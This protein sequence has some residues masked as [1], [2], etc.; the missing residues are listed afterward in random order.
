MR[1]L[2]IA[3]AII[4]AGVVVLLPARAQTARAAADGERSIRGVMHV[5]TR[6]SDGTGTIEQVADAA[7]RAGLAFVVVTDHGDA[8]RPPDAPAYHRGVLMIDAVEVSTAGGHVVALGLDGAPYPLG[9]APADVV[10]DIHRLGGIAIAA[11]PGSPRAELAW[12][13]W[14]APVDGLEWVNGDSEWRDETP[15][16]LLRGLLTYPFR[17]PEALAS[18]LDRPEPVMRQWDALAQQRPVVGLAASDAHARISLTSIGEP[19]DTHASLPFPS[20]SAVFG[21]MSIS[22]DGATLT[23]EPAMDARA[24]LEAIRAGHVVSQV[25]GL[26]RGGR[27]QLTATSGGFRGVGGDRLDTAGDVTLAASATTL[28]G[29]RLRLLKNGEVIAESPL[30]TLERVVGPEP[31]E[32]RA[33]VTLRDAPGVPPIPWLVGNPV[34]VNLPRQSAEVPQGLPTVRTAFTTEQLGRA[35]I[36]RSRES[37]GAISLTPGNYQREVLFRYAL[38]GASSDHPY[39]AA[40]FGM[41]QPLDGY[42]GVSF[43]ARTERPLRLSVQ[44]RRPG[45][46]G[47]VR[48]TRSVYLDATSRVVVLRFD[49]FSPVDRSSGPVPVGGLDSLLLVVDDV[50]TPLGNGGR[51]WI[52]DLDFFR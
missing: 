12:Q 22:L 37:A 34:Y 11:H 13:D 26:A 44:V 9:G 6:R 40:V 29:S 42:A 23:G 36:E 25:D 45:P 52:R 46:G 32:Y 1:L 50:N 31:A 41:P 24:V 33:E 27:L 16:S 43:I 28:P 38:G 10:E 17:G 7:A 2:I 47:G 4:A 18:L 35:R 19:Y 48:W 14:V 20:Y 15:W 21:A 8:S 39:A 30:S 51:V 49:Q 3:A 5:H